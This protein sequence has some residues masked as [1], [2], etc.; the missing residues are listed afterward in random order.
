MLNRV[1]AD[2]GRFNQKLRN[3]N[4]LR[5]YL[6]FTSP[7]RL[8]LQVLSTINGR[9]LRKFRFSEDVYRL[10]S[11]RNL[12]QSQK[13]APTNRGN[14]INCVCRNTEI[15]TRA[16]RRKLGIFKF[17][18][19]NN[20][21]LCTICFIKT[22]EHML[23][24]VRWNSTFHFNNTQVKTDFFKTWNKIGSFRSTKSH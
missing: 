15:T 23:V 14:Y 10:F 9:L 16:I 2:I 18:E 20:F 3:S 6:N 4:K 21:E 1:F 13:T 8:I 7:I 11:F 19:I 24:V 22:T 12:I 5:L 17:T